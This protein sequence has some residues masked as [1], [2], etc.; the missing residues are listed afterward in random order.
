MNLSRYESSTPVGLCRVIQAIANATIEIERFVRYQAVHSLDAPTKRS[1]Q[2]N[3][4][5]DDQKDLDVLSNTIM[6]THLM[7]SNSCNMLLSEEIAHPIK[8]PEDRKKGPYTVAFDPLDGSSNID[9][10]GPVGT[11]F[12]IWDNKAETVHLSGNDMIAAGYVLYGPATELILAMGSTVDRYVLEPSNVYMFHSTIKLPAKGKKIYS[13]NES[14]ESKWGED[15]KAFVKGYKAV[16]SGY[17]ARYIGSMVGDVHRTLL[18][19]G[20]FCYPADKKNPNGKLRVLY[21][22]FPMAKVMELAGGK[23]IVGNHST[24]RILDVKVTT[25]HQRSPILLGSV[26]EVQKYERL[27]SKL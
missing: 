15:I 19:G 7:Q 25:V 3:A 16:D 10:N 18:Y 8:V 20:V 14:A 4:S 2:Q 21:E 9:C 22:C 26:D 1:A 27:V 13:I 12:G 23:A 17:T 11:I 6:M 24:E 5:G